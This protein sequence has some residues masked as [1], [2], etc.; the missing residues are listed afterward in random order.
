MAGNTKKLKESGDGIYAPQHYNA[1][2]DD[3]EYA[4]GAEGAAY[5]T[6]KN[7]QKDFTF[8]SGTN[9]AGSKAY[10]DVAERGITVEFFGS[11]AGATATFTALSLIHI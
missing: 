7:P 9:V 2:I 1:G 10:S 4:Q 3:Y 5:V 11:A 6:I 8:A